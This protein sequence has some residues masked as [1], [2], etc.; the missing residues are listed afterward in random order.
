[1]KTPVLFLIFN[2]PELTF[3]V[4]EEIRK[5]QPEQL[6][7][8]ADGPREDREGESEKCEQARNIASKVDWS[9]EV[10]TLFRD[11]NLG[12]KMAVSSAINWFFEQ[13]EEGIILEDDCLPNQSFFF[14]CKTMLEKYRS[15]EKVMHI[16]G[17]NFQDK[18]K[19]GSASYYFS[20]HPN[21]WGWATWRR[22]WQHYDI[23][24]TDYFDFKKRQKIFSNQRIALFN[25][26]K[27]EKTL[28]GEINTWDY[29]WFYSI[30]VKKGICIIPNSNLIMNIG[31]GEQATHTFETKSFLSEVSTS[32]L[33]DIIHP[34]KIIINTKADEYFSWKL[35]GFKNSFE[36]MLFDLKKRTIVFTYPIY[37][38]IKNTYSNLH[39][40]NWL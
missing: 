37:R 4:F 22:A 40:N 16:G 29:Q 3:R 26:E 5:A 38:K 2:R 12:C 11:K 35:L 32:E 9:C 23:N 36:H 25:F 17:A 15:E 33:R 19:R 20:I 8:A 18:I 27:L 14:F 39:S 1:M 13:V 7:I 10:K 6:F 30:W 31:F 28:S 24:M 34:S 21:Q